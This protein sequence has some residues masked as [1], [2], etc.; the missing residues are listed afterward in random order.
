MGNP[1]SPLLTQIFLDS[2]ESK[3]SKNPL[4][5]KLNYWHRYVADVLACFTGTDRQLT[6]F[7]EYINN[8][9]NNIKFTIENEINN[10]INF[11][12]LTI[13]RDNDKHIF[14]FS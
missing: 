3:I 7:L 2:L 11:L 10:S 6:V 5:K 1:L 4:F 13:S 8:L 9:H 12:D 14:N